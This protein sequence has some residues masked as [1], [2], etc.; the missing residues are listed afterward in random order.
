M[1]LD[2]SPT[3]NTSNSLNPI[4]SK[5]A[6]K[7][8]LEKLEETSADDE[9]DIADTVDV[10]SHHMSSAE[11]FLLVNSG[12]ATPA[13]SCK[14]NTDE[15]YKEISIN[16]SIIRKPT[17][18]KES[19]ERSYIKSVSEKVPTKAPCLV[20]KCKKDIKKNS[21]ETSI[22]AIDEKSQAKIVEKDLDMKQKLNEEKIKDRRKEN[23]KENT[24]CNAVTEDISCSE[25]APN[26]EELSK[27]EEL[28]TTLM[29]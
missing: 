16:S 1:D 13:L 11:N 8:L 24:T 29:G 19:K 26:G 3:S 25:Q 17:N 23:R 7:R 4:S 27:L 9:D 18:P 12:P 21:E 22:S 20:T 5:C 15:S 6:L 28:R 14:H 10:F 2:I